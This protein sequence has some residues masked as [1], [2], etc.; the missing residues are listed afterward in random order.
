MDW[1]NFKRFPWLLTEFDSVKRIYVFPT[2]PS[3]DSVGGSALG[4]LHPIPSGEELTLQHSFKD[5]G[6]KLEAMKLTE[7]E[8]ERFEMMFKKRLVRWQGEKPTWKL[9]EGI[10]AVMKT[11]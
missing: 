5:T 7:V 10:V 8:A 9:P 6:G 1:P 3:D 11:I 2:H 4:D